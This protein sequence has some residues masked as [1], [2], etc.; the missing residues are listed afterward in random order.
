MS[1]PSQPERNV[2]VAL[3]AVRL[4]ALAHGLLEARLGGPAREL[5]A[6][7]RVP[8]DPVEE[9][10]ERLRGLQA[11]GEQ[12]LVHQQLH[13]HELVHGRERDPLDQRLEALVQLGRRRRLDGETPLERGGAVDQVSREEQA[14]G[15]LVAGA[16]RPQRRGGNAPDAGRRVADAGVVGDHEQIGAERH[17]GAARDAEAV[18]LADH[19]LVRAEQAHETAQVAAHHLPVHDRVPRLGR[20]VVRQRAGLGELDQVVA[21]AEPLARARERDHVDGGV[22]VGLLHAIGQ[23]AR[24]GE[25]DAVAA[26]GPVKRDPGNAPVDGVVERLHDRRQ[27]TGHSRVT[28]AAIAALPSPPM[29]TRTLA[30]VLALVACLLL[31]GTAHAQSNVFVNELHYDNAGTDAGEAIEIAAPQGTDLT[32]WDV[33]LYNGNGGATY[34]TT[35]EL[36]GTVGASRVT[37]L[38]YPVDGIQNGSPDGI[39]LVDPTGA[40][41]QFLS[42][43]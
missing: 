9:D 1:W 15:T 39:A 5:I 20:V 42:Y 23:L 17:V 40:V 28:R 4:V 24:H 13:H 11:L 8:R 29:P 26:L 18:H 41:R 25:R 21:A 2:K 35:R 16:E 34:G 27:P 10:A 36:S 30:G 32:G 22:E 7:W 31:A 3:I 12:G 33:V 43:E 19:G 37:V 38:E 6:L 14:L